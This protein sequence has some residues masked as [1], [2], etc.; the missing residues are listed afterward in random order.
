VVTVCIGLQDYQCW[1]DLRM[2]ESRVGERY[3]THESDDTRWNDYRVAN[4]L[5]E[6]DLLG[7]R[8]TSKD[9]A[10]NFGRSHKKTNKRWCVYWCVTLDSAV[11]LFSM[12]TVVKSC[13]RLRALWEHR[14]RQFQSFYVILLPLN[15]YNSV[16]HTALTESWGTILFNV[17]VCLVVVLLTTFLLIP[18]FTHCKTRLS[19]HRVAHEK[20]ECRKYLLNYGFVCVDYLCRVDRR[21]TIVLL[22]CC[23]KS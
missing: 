18:L 17:F 3:L 10:V 22:Q 1:C 13:R 2:L 20:V 21:R 8:G 5:P 19:V 16:F 15:G 4:G 9:D 12:F 11:C 23:S 14:F 6:W 7:L